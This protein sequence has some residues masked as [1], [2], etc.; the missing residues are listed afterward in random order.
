MRR[1]LILGVCVLASVVTAILAWPTAHYDVS[2]VHPSLREL[3]TP[4]RSVFTGYYLDGGSIGI[5]IVDREGRKLLL[6]L[7]VSSE[8][9]RSYPRLFIG[10]KHARETNAVEVVLSEDTRRMLISIIEQH[11]SAADS[12][13]IA[14]V[15]LRG[16]PRD[17]VRIYSHA[18]V[19]LCRRLTK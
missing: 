11:Q 17:Y 1:T 8:G 10:A 19:S 16:S 14:L 15:A 5:T 13:D 12:G 18:V 9:G 6:A 4:Y 3:A 2:R 7:P